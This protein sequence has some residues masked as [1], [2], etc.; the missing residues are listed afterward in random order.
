M[1]ETAREPSTRDYLRAFERIETLKNKL[2][3]MGLLDGGATHEE[4][5][6][7]VKRIV[8]KELITH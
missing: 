1:A 7:C 8:P 6:A 2:I 4:V 5:I 3:K